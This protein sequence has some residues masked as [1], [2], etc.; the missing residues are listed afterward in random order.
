M[1]YVDGLWLIVL[2]VL[3]V[4]G[5]IIAKRPD[6]KKII[7]KLAPFQGW[8]GVVSAIWGIVE[9]V[10]HWIRSFGLFHLGVKGLV[11]WV[12]FTVWIAVMIPL[13]FMLGI[14]IFKTWVKDPNA[15]A[16]MDQTLAKL[17]PKQG[18]LG[19]IAL[20]DGAAM[21]VWGLVG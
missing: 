2:G 3:A 4:P 17:A 13:G 16:K 7:D 11:A 18:V 9:L 20:I 21:F 8:I 12:I 5:L 14:G 10:W 19:L 6:A 15:Q 1:W